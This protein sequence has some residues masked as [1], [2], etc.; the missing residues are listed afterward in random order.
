MGPFPVGTKQAK[1]L[2]VAIDYFTKWVEAEPLATISEKNVKGFVWKAVIC[3]F[4]IL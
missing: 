3:R 2:V 1:F 4:R